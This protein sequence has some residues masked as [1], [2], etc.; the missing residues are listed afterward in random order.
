MVAK[1]SQLMQWKSLVL[2]EINN[3][4]RNR[5]LLMVSGVA[6]EVT[7]CY[8]KSVVSMEDTGFYCK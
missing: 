6:F 5:L 4:Y 2:W 7:G 1:E 3:L 8:G